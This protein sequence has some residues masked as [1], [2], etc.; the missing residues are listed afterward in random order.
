[1]PE[2]KSRRLKK[3]LKLIDVYAIAAGTTL[4]AGFFLLPGIAAL[5]AGPA[6]IFAY[7]LAALPLIPSMFSVIELATAMPRAGGVYYFLDRTL[8][9]MVGTIGGLGTYFAL[10]LKV[11]FALVGMGAYIALFFPDVSM[12]PIA[13]GLAVL[14]GILNLFGS[15][16]SGS[17]QV[18]LFFGLLLILTI[19][20]SGGI[21]EIKMSYFS[22]IFDVQTG[23]V[24]STAGLVYISYVGIT[25]IASL[26]EEIIKPE[27][28]LPLGTI[29][30]LSTAVLVYI[31]GT[32]VMVGVIP[33]DIFRGDLTPVAT[34]AEYIFGHFGSVL[35]SI[36]AIFAF[37][38]VANAGI[39]SSSRYPLAMS[40]D[41][42][43]PRIFQKLDKKGIP[44]I[45]VI[46]TIGI[47][48]ISLLF[49]NPTKIAKL[50]SAFQLLMFAM[51]CFAVIIM[52]E[53]KIESYDPGFKSPFYP[54]MQIFGILSSLFLI[55]E[56]GWVS[57]FFSFGL[58]TLGAFWYKFYAKNKVLRNGAIYHIFE[59][60]GRSRYPG[61]ERELRGIL[62]EK[63]LREEDPF[64]DI[65]AR[66]IV[67][68]LKKESEFPEVVDRVA[69][70]LSQ[71]VPYSP[72]EIA[73]QFL[74]GTRV[75]AT[76]VTHGMALPHL[77]IKGLEQP[78]MV[79]VRSKPGVHIIFNDP[80]TDDDETEENIHAIFFL[81]SPEQNP[82]QH[83]RILAQIAG[84]VDEE[85]FQKEWNAAENEQELK[86]ALIHDE[87][88]LSF[89]VENKPGTGEMI[90]KKLSELKIPE[91]CLVA[92]LKRNDEVTVPRGNTEIQRGDRLTIIGNP[93]AMHKI[94]SHYKIDPLNQQMGPGIK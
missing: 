22:G 20:I 2:L 79:I 48:I 35:L 16:K 62:K 17:L 19:F 12:I 28:N 57:S 4:S 86:E 78:E 23:T 85:N 31:L 84:R 73:K 54:W 89:F 9:P 83:L 36:G 8:G 88:Y 60:L 6:L 43:M 39:L 37:T 66:S 55:F 21:P 44:Y 18:F 30:A 3:E 91:G 49:L 82:A 52:R 76:P 69:G 72:E 1:M 90:G 70:W 64:D 26:S 94:K 77:R 11:S 92:W 34:A 7:I 32:I 46:V 74:E 56:M 41:H 25:K 24:F 33:M 53:S 87:R 15:K 5:E 68:D 71:T 51:I 75:G 29:L 50:A 14:L 45:S 13:I 47:I 10:L 61:L 81:V 38:S 67:W 27:K 58:V 59:R 63:G 80:L 40:R 65:V 42:L 93:A